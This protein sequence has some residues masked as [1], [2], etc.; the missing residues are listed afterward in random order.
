MLSH[1]V[2]G[3]VFAWFF[4]AIATSDLPLLYT[5]GLITGG[6]AV[7]VAKGWKGIAKLGAFILIG[8]AAVYAGIFLAGQILHT[9]A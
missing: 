2:V 3:L 7:A 5:V 4:N 9:R 8:I 1:V 6:T